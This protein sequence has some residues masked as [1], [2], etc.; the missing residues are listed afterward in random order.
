LDRTS[1]MLS[2]QP[3]TELKQIH[4]HEETQKAWADLKE[5]IERFTSGYKLDELQNN[6][7]ALVDILRNDQEG[8]IWIKDLRRYAKTLWSNPALIESEASV[9]ES[10]RLIERARAIVKSE[11]YQRVLQN[12]SKET[13]R[14]MKA[15]KHDPDRI[16][17]ADAFGQLSDDMFFSNGVPS[18][19]VFQETA[20]QL[21]YL[22]VPLISKQLE[23]IQVPQIEGYTPK[24]DFAAR[25][26]IFSGAEILPQNIQLNM[27]TGMNLALNE[28]GKS[29]TRSHFQVIISG[30]RMH[31]RNIDFYFHRKTFPRVSDE[32]R[33]AM[34][35]DGDGI[36][37]FLEWY[38]DLTEGEDFKMEFSRAICG[39]DKVDITLDAH[40]HK[41][42]GTVALALLKSRIR[43]S[44][45]K[46]F[47]ENLA[48][49]G[50]RGSQGI[51]DLFIQRR[52]NRAARH[53]TDEFKRDTRAQRRMEKELQ[54][55]AKEMIKQESRAY[56]SSSV[57]TMN[58]SAS[59]NTVPTVA[60][61][62]VT[63]EP[64]PFSN[65]VQVTYLDPIPPSVQNGL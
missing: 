19:Y 18:L 9:Q 27:E 45:E 43:K 58:T 36:S 42:V 49:I 53:K 41:L 63:G 47:A 21:R 55:K 61:L 31:V 25:N 26:L 15:I 54:K 40:K 64:I 46:I 3:G 1:D 29:Y 12:T 39:I 8:R 48:S 35:F 6:L 7:E 62:I 44:L 28:G 5:L 60:P 11:R 30:V 59:I 34:D 2:T 16:A 32:G 22:L 56:T 10:R 20:A 50:I 33:M 13:K 65:P 14:I 17:L 52:I 57:S 23:N 4:K 51:N 37:I 38:A 24:Y